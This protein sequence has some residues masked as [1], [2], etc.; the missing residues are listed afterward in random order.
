M[1]VFS[2]SQ[3]V[4]SLPKEIHIV[5]IGEWKERGFRI[6]AEDCDDIIRNFDSFGI[7][8]VIDYEHQSLN[9]NGNGSPAPAAGWIGKLEKRE[10]GVWA[11][12]LEWTED[13]KKYIEG[14]QYRYISPVIVFDD[15]DPHT[16]TWIGCSLHSVALTNVPYFRDDLEAIVNSRYTNNKP[17]EAGAK[18]EKSMTLEEQI[19]ALKAENASQA[20]QVEALKRDL[21]KQNETLQEQETNKLVEDAIAAKKLLPAQKEVGL[22]VAKQG[23]DAFAKFIACNV[24]PDLTKPDS[25][26]EAGADSVKYEDLLK[27]PVRFE[28]FKKDQ[29]EAF[30]AA[31]KAFY[32]E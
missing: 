31:R 7:K 25:V 12:D 22:I 29:P 13:A 10:N 27:D 8:L 15:R 21:A 4:T 9:C 17:A 14:K 2:M 11:T 18:K 19:A 6:T 16:D 23:K 1:K 26:P 20:T 32:K 3:D 28:K 30:E 24:L 5:P